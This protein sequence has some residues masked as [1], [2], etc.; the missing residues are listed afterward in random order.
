MLAFLFSHVYI[1][2]ALGKPVNSG[3]TSTSRVILLLALDQVFS[4]ASMLLPTPAPSVESDPFFKTLGV[5]V[6]V[7]FKLSAI[8]L[9]QPPKSW[10]CSMGLHTH[11]S[12]ALYS[13]MPSTEICL[14]LLAKRS[15]IFCHQNI[16]L[17]TLR[18]TCILFNPSTL[19]FTQ[20]T[21]VG[22]LPSQW[23][24][25]F[26]DCGRHFNSPSF[27]LYTTVHAHMA[28]LAGLRICAG[29]LGLAWGSFG[30]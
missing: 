13:V 24:S 12:K 7:G 16:F 28:S 11:L 6:L 5:G 23:L 1:S 17:A 8:L 10:Y 2:P 27:I 20:R 26:M 9:P 30:R 15:C 18:S 25:L 21:S 19:S 4:P 29:Y 14:A 22:R 3:S